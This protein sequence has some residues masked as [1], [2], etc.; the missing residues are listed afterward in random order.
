[1]NKTLQKSGATY[2]SP[3]WKIYGPNIQIVPKGWNQDL[4]L[5]D[6]G[7]DHD[8]DEVWLLIDRSI[9]MNSWIIYG[10]HEQVFIL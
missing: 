1:M 3:G 7:M 8:W 9:V 10:T 6:M 2:H 5:G 4:C